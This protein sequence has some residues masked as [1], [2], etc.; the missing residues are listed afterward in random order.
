MKNAMTL[1]EKVMLGILGVLVLVLGYYYL[2]Y[3][4]MK[5]ETE[6][7]KQE[8]IT[9]DDTLLVVEAKVMKMMKM[10]EEID[11]IKAGNAEG[12]KELPKYDNRQNLMSQLSA[13]LAKTDKYNITFGSVTGDGTTNERQVT[14]NYACSD[15]ASAKAILQEI[16]AGQYPCS[17]GNVNFS[18]E[19]ATV[20]INIT[21][22]E[23]G[24]L[25]ETANQ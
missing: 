9:V 17:F 18:N 14:L 8:Y 15:Y 3:I 23:Y 11:A 4:P 7:Y 6:Q 5:E 19:G 12:N 24:K 16:Y 25:E 20:A 13:I 1:R 22:Y 2:V 21:Y 10:Q